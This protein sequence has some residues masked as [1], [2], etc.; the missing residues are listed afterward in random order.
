MVH[1]KLTY[2][3]VRGL[4]EVSRLILHYAGVEFEDKRITHDEWPAIKP[5]N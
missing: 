3:D 1:Y 5:S 4:A 2:F